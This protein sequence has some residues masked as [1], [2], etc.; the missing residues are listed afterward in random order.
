MRIL[1]VE[2][3]PITLAVIA[4]IARRIPDVEV[5]DCSDPLEAMIAC[6]GRVHDLVLIDYMMPGMNGIDFIRALKADEVYRSVP[7]VMITAD[8]ER[9]LRIEAIEAGATDFLNKPVDPEELK[10]RLRN[11][12]ALRRAQVELADR[13]RW[14][15]VEVEKATRELLEREEE[16]IWRL[17]RAIDFRDGGTGAHISRVATISRIV[18]EEMGLPPDHCRMIYLAAPLHDV[19]KIGVDDAILNKPGRLDPDELAQMRRHV[20]YGAAI[21]ENGRASLIQVAERIA[22][23]HHERWDGAGYPAGLAGEEIPVEGRVAAIADVFDALC[24]R[25]PYKHAWDKEEAK[26]EIRSLAGSHFDPA[27][28]AAFERGWERIAAVVETVVETVG[29]GQ[30][31][32]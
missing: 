30:S 10:V 7:V 21:L 8:G 14:L 16:M 5:I 27:C 18:A 13:A 28:V 1:V 19:G 9:A 12:L 6:R 22:R 2:D 26:A 11:L 31:A 24:A 25:R 32:A 17:A 15:A 23:C 20:A 29:E 4:N 3:N